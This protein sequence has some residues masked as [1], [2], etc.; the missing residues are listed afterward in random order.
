MVRRLN[1]HVVVVSS[2]CNVNLFHLW[3]RN[4][5]G[6]LLISHLLTGEME[7]EL[8]GREDVEPPVAI[9]VPAPDEPTSDERRHHGLTHLPYKPWCNICVRARGR[10][11]KHVSR[12]QNQPG[13]PVIQCDFCFLKTEED[14][15]MVTAFVLHD[16]R[17]HDH[18]P[19]DW[20]KWVVHHTLHISTG[21]NGE[22][23]NAKQ[24]C[25]G[26]DG[27]CSAGSGRATQHPRQQE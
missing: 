24:R 22:K 19:M 9:E 4:Q 26:P 10:G 8:M 15:P 18:L 11:N 17:V 14:A 16:K 3:M 25:W 1:S 5:R 20:V 6:K 13:T 12:S 23:R 27:K 2:F 21:T 7:R